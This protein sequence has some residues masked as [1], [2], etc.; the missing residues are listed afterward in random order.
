MH[1]CL[2][3]SVVTD[4]MQC[5]GLQRARLLCP[6][7]S[8]GK[9]TGVQNGKET[10]TYM[11]MHVNKYYHHLRLGMLGR[12]LFTLRS[13]R[14]EHYRGK[15]QTPEERCYS[16]GAGTLVGWRHRSDEAGSMSAEKIAD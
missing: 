12:V 4:S 2:V 7:D 5:Y 10:I 13:F 8:P 3:I 11:V 1:A 6:W 14:E 15:F 9:D 16:V